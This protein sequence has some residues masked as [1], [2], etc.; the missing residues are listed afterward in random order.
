[1]MIHSTYTWDLVWAEI[2]YEIALNPQYHGQQG[3]LASMVKKFFDQKKGSGATSKA[4]ANVNE[5]I[6]H[7]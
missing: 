2:A 5:K 6:P 7:K 1:M 4:R 3:G